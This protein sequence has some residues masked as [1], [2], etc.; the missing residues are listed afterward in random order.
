MRGL[1]QAHPVLPDRGH[2]S[3]PHCWRDG[4]TADLR[5]H[6]T[7]TLVQACPASNT[8]SLSP[9]FPPAADYDLAGTSGVGSIACLKL[10]RHLLGP[11]A[12]ARS[13]GLLRQATG[14]CSLS[15][16]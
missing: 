6:G 8:T 15:T 1:C 13:E 3:L 10:L 7:Q 14:V 4:C 2:A 5:P 12:Q 9:P 11:G 16:V